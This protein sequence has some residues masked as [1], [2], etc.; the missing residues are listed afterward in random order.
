MTEMEIR[1]LGFIPTTAVSSTGRVHDSTPAT[2]KQGMQGAALSPTGQLFLQA[3]RE[4]D[5][6]PEVRSHLVQSLSQQLQNGRYEVNAAQVATAM[7]P[8][9]QTA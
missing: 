4:L 1:G 7:V 2:A 8:E 6:L 3:R 5:Q 9:A